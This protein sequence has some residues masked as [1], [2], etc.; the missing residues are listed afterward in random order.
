[1]GHENTLLD[2]PFDTYR[3]Y[4]VI[5]AGYFDAYQ[6]PKGLFYDARSISFSSMDQ[7]EFEEVY[8][9][10]LDK[11]ISDIGLTGDEIEMQLT[12]FM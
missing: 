8:S 5:K 4:M 9:R 2:M 10:V 6:T 1:V 3:K 12:N 7:A 11:I